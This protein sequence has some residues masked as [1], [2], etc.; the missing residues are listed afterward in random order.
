[1]LMCMCVYVCICVCVCEYLSVRALPSPLALDTITKGIVCVLC[2]KPS[3]THHYTIT[4]SQAHA[5]IRRL[6]TGYLGGMFSL[7]DPEDIDMVTGSDPAF[8]LLRP[9]W[10]H[11]WN[12]RVYM[13]LKVFL[14]LCRLDFQTRV[15][16]T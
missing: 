15:E 1:M 12:G 9:V 13:Y 14:R 6:I 16:V 11:A 4:H 3:R 5:P 2:T 10:V 8:S 7:F